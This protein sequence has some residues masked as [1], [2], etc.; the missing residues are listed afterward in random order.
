[1]TDGM[2]RPTRALTLAGARA[3][4]DAALARAE[5][6]D[7]RMNVAVVDAGGTIVAFA[8]MDGAFNLSGGIARDKAKTVVGFGGVPSAGLYE[9]LKDEPAVR[10]GIANREGVAA[11]GGGVPIVVDGELVGAV[12]ASGGSAE[13]DTQ[14]AQAG[15]DALA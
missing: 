8:R 2:T 15:A 7:A 1:M 5:E 9:G 13:E 11:F 10:D 6:I 3:A 4:L 12:G 14:V